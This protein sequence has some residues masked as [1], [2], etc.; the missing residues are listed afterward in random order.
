MTKIP[1]DVTFIIDTS[2]SMAGQSIEQAKASLTLALSRLTTQDRFNI[3]QFNN[4]VRSLFSDLQPVTAITIKK[5]VRF[6][7][8]LSAD[9]GTEMLPALRQALKGSEDLHRLQQVILLTDGQIGN[10]EELFE[11][12]HHRLGTRRV[13]TVGI[14]S[15]PNSHLMRKTAELSRGT[16]TYISNTAEVKDKLDGLFRKLERPV[17]SDLQFDQTGWAGSEQYPSRIADLYEGEPLV[18]ALKARSLPEQMVLHGQVGTNPWSLPVSMKQATARS[19]LSVYWARQKISALMDE[20]VAGGSEDTIRKAVLD[21][22]LAHHLVSKYTSL[23][24]IDMTSA[25]PTDKPLTDHVLATNLAHG[26][27]Y[28]AIFGLPRTATNGPI[29]LLLG[30]SLLVTFWMVWLVKSRFA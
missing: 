23:V 30:I 4:R 9:G 3:I 7:D 10:E 8:H 17:L 27:D 28:Y 15:A 13:F 29:H 26:Q 2:G 11:L 16:F 6:A 1:R 22:A 12:L 18:I 19:G 24:A 20:A 21:V 25:R 5:A 14:G